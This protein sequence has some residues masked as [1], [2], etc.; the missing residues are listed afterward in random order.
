M[1]ALTCAEVHEQLDLLAAGACDP[2]IRAAVEAHLRDCPSCAADYAT[3]QRLQGLLDLHWSQAGVERLRQRIEQNARPQRKLRFVTPFVHP[4]VLVAALLLI[5]VGLIAWLPK[6]DG[7]TFE[8]QL[9]LLVPDRTIDARLPARA[10]DNPAAP[11]HAKGIEAMAVTLPEARSG[12]M[13]R[14]ELLKAQGDGKLPPPSAIA[15]TLTLV[16]NGKRPIEVRLGDAVPVLALEVQG[17][18]VL[19]I[20]AEAKAPAFLQPRTLHL[21]PGQQHVIQIDRPWWRATADKLTGIHLS[22]RTWRIHADRP[23]AA[24]HR[25]SGRDGDGDDGS[26]QGLGTDPR[27]Y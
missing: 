18:G 10:L 11:L 27:V 6:Q 24:E 4:A 20:A 8:P 2:P 9:A 19:R 21:E 23:I 5:A 7:K 17:D 15:L 12:E 25:R 13:L 3:S 26:H 16:N 1:N 14:R 22:H